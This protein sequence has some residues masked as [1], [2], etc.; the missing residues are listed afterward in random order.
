MEPPEDEDQDVEEYVG[1]KE[2]PSTAIVDHPQVPPLL[3]RARLDN[4]LV[5]CDGRDTHESLQSR[6]FGFVALQ[7]WIRSVE[8][9]I[10][11]SIKTS[12]AIHEIHSRRSL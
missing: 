10:R 12:A 2:Q 11:M 5:V 9:D 1:E 6:P 3:Q 4:G 7:D 8:D